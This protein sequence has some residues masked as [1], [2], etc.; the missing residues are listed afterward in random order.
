MKCANQSKTLKRKIEGHATPAPP[1]PPISAHEYIMW[2]TPITRYS[3]QKTKKCALEISA[4]SYTCFF[5]TRKDAG[6]IGVSVAPQ[7]PPLGL[8]MHHTDAAAAFIPSKEMGTR[9][10]VRAEIP[11]CSAMCEVRHESWQ[12]TST[13]ELPL[14]ICSNATTSSAYAWGVQYISIA[15]QQME[16]GVIRRPTSEKIT[17][18]REHKK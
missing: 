3:T 10:P 16:G 12:V 1:L 13:L 8:L 6:H 18:H 9:R 5:V 4:R 2:T 17:H 14:S 7:S 11:Q 15:H